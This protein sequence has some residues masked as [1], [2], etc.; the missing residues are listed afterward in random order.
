MKKLLIALFAAAAFT[1]SAQTA[2][3]GSWA[4]EFPKDGK[5]VNISQTFTPFFK[6]ENEERVIDMRLNERD[7]NNAKHWLAIDVAFSTNKPK[8]AAQWP[9]WLD[10]VEVEINVFLPT[11]DDRGNISWT[12]IGGKQTLA[13][14]QANDGRHFVRMMV[15]PEVI[16]R[17]FVF[18]GASGDFTKDYSKITSDLKKYAS[19][20]PVM[21][22]ISYGG[23]TV[24]GFQT[25]G[26]EIFNRLDKNQSNQRTKLFYTL[27]KGDGDGSPTAASTAKLFDYITKNKFNPQTFKYMPDELLP[28]SKTPFAWVL[29][30]RFEAIKET[31]GK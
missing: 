31:S 22:A 14:L 10:N 4:I 1:V 26:K 30:D 13:S 17:H 18:D 21:A 9:K 24:Y 23:R 12:V 27:V 25:C 15:P 3:S 2:R 16:Y 29:F 20:L 8:S 6:I 28:V 19:D 5:A 11:S 7:M